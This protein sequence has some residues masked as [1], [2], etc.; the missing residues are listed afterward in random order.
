MEL[1]GLH[2]VIEQMIERLDVAADG[3]LARAHIGDDRL[4]RDVLGIDDAAQLQT[5]DD[6]VERDAVDLGDRLE[7]GHALGVEREQDVL[8]VEARQ[9]HKRL[10]RADALLLEQLLVAAVAADDHGLGQQRAQLLAALAVRLDDLDLHVL[11][12][13]QLRQIIG[14][15]A[16]ADDHTA[17]HGLAAHV[18][19]LED[20]V[21]VARGGDDHDLVALG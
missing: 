6:V 17:A 16:A 10:R 2:A 4:R 9:R 11:L 3:V 13:Q 8:L 15:L 12:E 14:G 20:A 1:D 18:D 19:A 5:L 21:H 7:A